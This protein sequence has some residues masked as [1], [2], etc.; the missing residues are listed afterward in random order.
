MDNIGAIG[1]GM[2]GMQGIQGIQGMQD[3]HDMQSV[4]GSKDVKEIGMSGQGINQQDKTEMSDELK[5]NPFMQEGG[6]IDVL[7]RIQDEG[8]AKGKEDLSKGI[9]D[10]IKA[11]LDKQK[12]RGVDK[13][14]PN[15]KDARIDESI[16]SFKNNHWEHVKNQDI[17]SDVREAAERLIQRDL[18]GA[19][20]LINYDGNQQEGQGAS[21][22]G[23]ANS[24]IAGIQ[25]IGQ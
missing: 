7:K 1:G 15:Q 11:V 20:Q 22:G 8:K 6:N 3:M 25:G 5:D 10:Q 13:L 2:Q 16:N 24:I 9:K 21:Q 23:H 17:D 14:M 4:Q 19:A 18:D 12:P